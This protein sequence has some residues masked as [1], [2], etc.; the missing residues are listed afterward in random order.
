[1]H[2]HEPDTAHDI[3]VERGM[4]LA[5][6]PKQ[7]WAV[8]LCA[9]ERHDFGPEQQEHEVVALVD[10]TLMWSVYHD[11]SRRLPPPEMRAGIDRTPV[12]IP[13]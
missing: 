1:M 3:Y 9:G 6:G 5:Y 8:A 12:T 4:V 10:N 11:A 2:S 13:L 7:D